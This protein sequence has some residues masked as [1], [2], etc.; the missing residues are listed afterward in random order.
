[1]KYKEKIVSQIVDLC[2]G[3]IDVAFD[4]H[5]EIRSGIWEKQQEETIIE[6]AK[7]II[8]LAERNMKDE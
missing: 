3:I 4:S 5:V 7:E 6:Y 2:N 1:M 8:K